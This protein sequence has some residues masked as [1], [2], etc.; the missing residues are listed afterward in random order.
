MWWSQSVLVVLH[1]CTTA[2]S[3]VQDIYEC[4]IVE[5][6][7]RISSTVLFTLVTKESW[8]IT[9]FL[10][11]TK[12]WLRYQPVSRAG[13]GTKHVQPVMPDLLNQLCQICSTLPTP[14]H[15]TPP[16][17]THTLHLAVLSLILIA[18]RTPYLELAMTP[19][20][21]YLISNIAEFSLMHQL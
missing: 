17:P 18:A 3:Q 5:N 19:R 15:P 1:F 6:F 8:I 7:A 2:S 20:P 21:M 11:E 16:H 12:V 14:P 13:T 9:R 10:Q 4:R